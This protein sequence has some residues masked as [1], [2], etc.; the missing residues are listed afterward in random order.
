MITLSYTV[1]GQLIEPA[2]VPQYL[3][4]DTVGVYQVAFTFDADWAD[5]GEKTVVFRNPQVIDP[6]YRDVPVEFPLDANGQALVPAALLDPGKL[7]IGVYGTN[8]TQQFPTIWAPPLQVVPGASPGV[9]PSDD[10][11]LGSVI[12]TIPQTLTEEE[13]AQARENIGANEAEGGTPGNVVI[14]DNNKNIA[15]S[16]IGKDNLILSPQLSSH[17]YAEDQTPYLYRQTGGGVEVGTREYDSIVGGSV[18]HQQLVQYGAGSQTI[19]GVSIRFSDTGVITGSGTANDTGASSISSARIKAVA[20]TNHV[21]YM[22]ANLISGA[23]GESMFWFGNSNTTFTVNQP[24]IIKLSSIA[25]QQMYIRLTNGIAYN[26]EMSVSMIDL[27]QRFG[28]AVAD[29]LLAMETASAGSGIAVLNA[30]GLD[31]YRPYTATPSLE[32]VRGLQSHKTVGF[33]AWDEEWE[34][35]SINVQTGVNTADASRIRSKNLIR[36]IGG[37]TY[38]VHGARISWIE[39][40]ASGAYIRAGYNASFIGADDVFAPSSDASYIRFFTVSAYGGTYKHDICINISDPARNGQYE[41]YE[42]HTYPLDSSLTL[43]GVAVID[44][45]G[46]IKFDG[47]TYEP[48]GTVTRR[49]G[50]VTLTGDETWSSINTG[51]VSVVL[52]NMMPAPAGGP[53]NPHGRA[54]GYVT[55]DAFADVRAVYSNTYDKA[56]VFGSGYIG[57]ISRLYIRDNANAPSVA[58]WESYLSTHPLT[59]VYELATPTVETA[60]P[61]DALQICDPLGTEEYV[62]TGICPVGHIT[63]YPENQVAKLDGL[64]SDFSTL[65]AP[66]EKAYTATR[67]YAVGRLLIVDN[68]LYKAQTAIASG[69]TLTVGTNITATTLDE[70]IASL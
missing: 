9:E 25:S 21:L 24:K 63:Q 68:H 27:T 42:E 13:K 64:P 43:R 67:A 49:Y 7:F 23:Y 47:D 37:L 6:D 60:T 48:N 34:T 50:I 41:P 69:A 46:N 22:F 18:V 52:P 12:R 57:G 26:F 61:Y 39:Y 45:N 54:V 31:K 28:S 40:D 62:T 8:S 33:N 55:Y 59:V 4:A 15:D 3:V 35:G 29:R 44:A 70:V 19:K 58:D 56:V 36:I 38:F 11:A 14:I 65:I 5:M 16:G 17:I 2:S 20:P 51:L 53:G 66:T 32:S 10:P 30:M 1:A